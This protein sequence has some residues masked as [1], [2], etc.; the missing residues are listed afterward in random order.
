LP[1]GFETEIVVDAAIR[2]TKP[3]SVRLAIQIG[4]DLMT[5]CTSLH[6]DVGRRQIGRKCRGRADGQRDWP[7]R[8]GPKPDAPIGSLIRLK[9][10]KCSGLQACG[11]KR[12]AG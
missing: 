12:K 11:R 10:R 8:F 4:T 5:Y 9:S 6:I 1:H 7:I 2:K 3:S